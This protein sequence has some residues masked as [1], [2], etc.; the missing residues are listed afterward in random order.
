LPVI[1]AAA[2]VLTGGAG[3]DVFVINYSNIDAARTDLTN[4]VT[5]SAMDNI[6]DLN[7]GGNVAGTNVD[8]IQ[9]SFAVDKLVSAG[10]PVAMAATAAD[11]FDAVQALYAT[12]GVMDTAALGTAGLFTYGGDSFVVAESGGNSVFD[13]TDIIVKVTG[14]TGTLSLSD[15]VV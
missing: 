5:F 14:V 11:L 2:D 6:T 1:S 4:Q 9:L 3:N 8:T 10:A 15:L 13:T 12:G 7:L